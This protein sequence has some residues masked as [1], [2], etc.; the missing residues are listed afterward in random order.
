MGGNTL[1]TLGTIV[2]EHW[3]WRDKI[4]QL[5]L[6]ELRKRAR[7]A[8][9]GWAWFFIKPGVY[10]VCFWFALSVGLRA[11]Q[12][13]SSPLD[14]L[15]SVWLCAGIFPWFFMTQMMG[16][17][18]DVFHRYSYLVN[19]IKFPIS[20]IPAIYSGA[21]MIIQLMLQVAMVAIYFWGGGV[22]DLYL[23]QVPLMLFIMYA[24]WTVFSLFYS[25]LSAMSKDA[26]NFMSALSTPIFWLSGVIFNVERISFDWAQAILLFDPVTFIVKGF[27]CAYYTKTWI[28]EDPTA[29]ACFGIVFLV[30]FVLMLVVHRKFG[31]E[32][33]DVL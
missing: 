25:H 8:V 23:L 3:K 20:C 5:S 1:S 26:K 11:G 14:L 19:K 31:E 2:S 16:A 27:R 12:T 6:F 24:F 32:V 4:G 10:A 28:W 15:Y 33:A 17:G 21:T 30:T 7:G 18:I 9:L 22:L 13:V 29:C